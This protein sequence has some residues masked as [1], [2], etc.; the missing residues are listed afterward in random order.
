MVGVVGGG[1]AVALVSHSTGR[2]F[3]ETA[4]STFTL[5]LSPALRRVD[6]VGAT[7]DRTIA[8]YVIRTC[9][10]GSNGVCVANRVCSSGALGVGVHSGNYKVRGIRGTVR[11]LFAAINNR[12]TNLNFTMVRDFVSSVGIGSTVRG[13]A[14][15]VLTG[16]VDGH[17]DIGN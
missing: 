9:G 5:R 7:I 6:S 15:I 10:R 1:F 16:G 17:F 11:P 12:H 2:N 8:G 14:A 3:M 13:N 4:I